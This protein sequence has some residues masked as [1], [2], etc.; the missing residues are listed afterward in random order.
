MCV[1][2]LTLMDLVSELRRNGSTP[3][4]QHEDQLVALLRLRR[5][6]RFSCYTSVIYRRFSCTWIP[7]GRTKNTCL[8]GGGYSFV[9]YLKSF[10]HCPLIAFERVWVGIYEESFYF[11][12][13][14]R[15]KRF[16]VRA[17]SPRYKVYPLPPPTEKQRKKNTTR[18]TICHNFYPCP[19]EERSIR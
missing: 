8:W 14:P 7:K 9:A 4:V 5:L 3:P 13:K 12:G 11:L 19:S 1:R 16:A 6:Q 15:K 17:R 18:N 2:H 10:D